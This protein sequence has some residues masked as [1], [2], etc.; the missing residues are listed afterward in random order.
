MKYVH[1]IAQFDN[2]REINEA[3][4]SLQKITDSPI[5]TFIQ[6]YQIEELSEESDQDFEEDGLTYR[7][8]C[9][10]GLNET[11]FKKESTLYVPKF[12]KM[13][14]IPEGESPIQNIDAKSKRSTLRGSNSNEYEDR[15]HSQKQSP[16]PLL[17]PMR[18]STGSDW[19]DSDDMGSA[20]SPSP[21]IIKESSILD[22]L[23]P[24][25]EETHSVID[26]PTASK[27]LVQDQHSDGSVGGTAINYSKIKEQPVMR[28]AQEAIDEEILLRSATPG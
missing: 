4:F 2:L 27:D 9:D 19:I 1:S 17:K 21:A 24:I 22:T 23:E 3:T 18:Q 13:P 20:L 12:S 5:E 6:Y 11:I 26:V 25:K 7:T 10:S 16:L 15:Q 8:P 28:F 14:V